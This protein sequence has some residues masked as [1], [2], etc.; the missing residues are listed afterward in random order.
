MINMD[1]GISFSLQVESKDDFFPQIFKLHE[2]NLKLISNARLGS[3]L[4]FYILV[5]YFC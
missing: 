5:H 4:L 1:I 2:N 3:K